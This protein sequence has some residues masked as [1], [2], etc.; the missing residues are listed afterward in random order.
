[1]LRKELKGSECDEE[2]RAKI[3][4]PRFKCQSRYRTSAWLIL[5]GDCSFPLRA[6]HATTTETNAA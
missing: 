5:E 2:K 1:M 3:E 6:Y 4:W